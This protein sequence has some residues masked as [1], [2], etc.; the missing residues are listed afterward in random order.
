MR[1][2][3]RAPRFKTF[4]GARIM[5]LDQFGRPLECVVRNLSSGGACLA[6]PAPRNVP[7]NFQLLFHTDRSV[8]QCRV[9]WRREAQL[10][11]AFLAVP[12]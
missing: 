2:Q 3:R 4:K 6:L 9:V 10:G 12:A 5:M 8:H 1:E 11:V 7:D